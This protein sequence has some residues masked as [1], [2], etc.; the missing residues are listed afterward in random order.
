MPSGAQISMRCIVL[1]IL[2]SPS[3]SINVVFCLGDYSKKSHLKSHMRF[4]LGEKE[5]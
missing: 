4:V 5:G 1:E 3:Y 2:I